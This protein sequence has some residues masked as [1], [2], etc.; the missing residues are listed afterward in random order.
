M[1]VFFQWRI[2]SPFIQSILW[3]LITLLRSLS[4]Q[5]KRF[6]QKNN[7]WVILI[8]G[9]L[10]T[11]DASVWRVRHKA[12]GELGRVFVRFIWRRVTKYT[13]ST[14]YPEISRF[15]GA[16]SITCAQLCIITGT[17]NTGRKD[18]P[19]G[20]RNNREEKVF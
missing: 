8:R 14:F 3:T 2:T 20:S 15:P 4:Y 10:Q 12:Q 7:V 9:V 13:R 11:D 16:S 19:R 17:G 18:L 1:H 5:N 6:V